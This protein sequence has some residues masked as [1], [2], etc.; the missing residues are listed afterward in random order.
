MSIPGVVAPGVFLPSGRR[1]HRHEGRVY[2]GRPRG[3]LAD[4]VVTTMRKMGA[5]FAA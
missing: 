4:E 5:T 3:C 2:G 1:N